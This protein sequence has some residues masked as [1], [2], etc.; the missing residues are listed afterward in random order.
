MCLKNTAR[1]LT[2]W[3]WLAI[4]ASNTTCTVG[5]FQAMF[6]PA[7][8]QLYPWR[9]MRTVVSE[10]SAPVWETMRSRAISSL[11][12]CAAEL[13]AWLRHTALRPAFLRASFTRFS[14]VT[15]Q[16]VAAG[17]RGGIVAAGVWVGLGD[18]AQASGVGRSGAGKVM[19][20][21]G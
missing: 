10:P 14:S 20:S 18:A 12:A 1:M 11:C 6:S 16:S 8:I 9:S 17:A 15:R 3:Y 4:Q 13:S 2:R 5:W 19:C 7:A 21:W